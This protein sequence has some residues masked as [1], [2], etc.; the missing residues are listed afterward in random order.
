MRFNWLHLTG[1]SRQ[2]IHTDTAEALKLPIDQWEAQKLI[3]H[4]TIVQYEMLKLPLSYSKVL[5]QFISLSLVD[6]RSASIQP[7]NWSSAPQLF[8]HWIHA[9]IKVAFLF[10]Q[11][12]S[13]N[14]AQIQS[15]QNIYPQNLGMDFLVAQITLGIDFLVALNTTAWVYFL[16]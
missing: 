2:F 5:D 9:F 11:V 8:N 12:W 14:L 1:K 16:L 4:F 15:F 6:G 7:L 13:E 3:S 10:F